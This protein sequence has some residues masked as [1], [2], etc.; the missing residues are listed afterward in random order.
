LW[1]R[2]HD[3]RGYPSW[4]SCDRDRMNQ[5]GRHGARSMPWRRAG[6]H[7]MQRE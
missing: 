7:S 4:P 5:N 6:K 1:L 3:C 2:L